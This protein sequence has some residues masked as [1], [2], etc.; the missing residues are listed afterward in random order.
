[1]KIKICGI[2]SEREAEIAVS[3]GADLL[4]FVFIP[5]PRRLDP[6]AA[7]S[8]I[9][10]LPSS[11]TPVGV[12]R[13][14][15]LEDVR[16]LLGE[17]GVRAAQLNG[18]ES[19]EFAGALGVEVIKTFTQFTRR[20]LE[21]LARYDSFACLA[22]P[23]ARGGLDAD[24]ATCAKKFANVLIAAPSDFGALHQ[25]IHRIRPWGVDGSGMKDAEKIRAL[26]ETVRA[27]EQDTHKIR[28]T[29]RK[30]GSPEGERGTPSARSPRQSPAQT[31][32]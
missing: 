3:V 17:S 15:P 5:G 11:V 8:I 19:P 25:S 10:K 24:W 14:H 27:A 16:T 7:G 9:R 12:F 2:A 1:M 18:T 29:I 22:D 4:G 6:R 13:N 32:A 23:G 28:V 21:D 26:V 20:S 31:P 30:P